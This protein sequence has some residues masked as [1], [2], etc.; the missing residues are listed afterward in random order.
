MPDLLAALERH[1]ELRVT[2]EVRVLLLEVSPSLRHRRRHRLDGTPARMGTGEA[3]GG[4]RHAP[5]PSATPGSATGPQQLTDI[6]VGD[7]NVPD[8]QPLSGIGGIAALLE[9]MGAPARDP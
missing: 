9:A 1:W 7:T 6:N 3:A 2:P 5:H 4:H 8:G